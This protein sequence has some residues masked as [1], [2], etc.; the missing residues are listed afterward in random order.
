MSGLGVWVA[1]VVAWLWLHSRRQRRRLA[2]A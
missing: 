2:R 1:A